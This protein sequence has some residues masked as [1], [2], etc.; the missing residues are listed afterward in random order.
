MKERS[1]CD[2]L[3][4]VRVCGAFVGRDGFQIRKRK[5][6]GCPGFCRVKGPS[7]CRGGSGA[8][9]VGASVDDDD[10]SNKSKMSNDE[11]RRRDASV[12]LSLPISHLPM[13]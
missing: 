8:K 1:R 9:V 10:D 5:S 13:R 6:E 3:H 12:P 11:M 7:K 2:W 4:S